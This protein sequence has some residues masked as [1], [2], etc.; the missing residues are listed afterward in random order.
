MLR[1]AEAEY[2]INL[3]ENANSPGDFWKITNC[4]LKKSKINK[5]GL[6]QD[7]NGNVITQV[8]YDAVTNAI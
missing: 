6:I 2:W 7:N 4:I 5:C 1:K 3:S 8:S